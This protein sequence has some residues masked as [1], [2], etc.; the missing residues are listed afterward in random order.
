MLNFK[1]HQ[2]EDPRGWAG[3]AHDPADRPPSMKY[4]GFH[5]AIHI[6]HG[7]HR[8]TWPICLCNEIET[9]HLDQIRLRFKLAGLEPPSYTAMVVK[10]AA[11]A[12]RE[13]SK[14]YPEINS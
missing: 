5:R 10:A 14:S 8:E 7:E 4:T 2:D 9:D 13:V 3:H 6:L 12:I 1:E 11:M